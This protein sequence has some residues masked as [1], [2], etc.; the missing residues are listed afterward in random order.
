MIWS[1]LEDL[2]QSIQDS[3]VLITGKNSNRFGTGFVIRQ[4]QGVARVLTCAHVLKDVGGIESALVDGEPVD[5]IVSNPCD[6]LDLAILV[7]GNLWKNALELSEE[8]PH[9]GQACLVAGWYR[10]SISVSTEGGYKKDY[11]ETLN[12]IEGWLDQSAQ[13]GISKISTWKL[14]IG[15]KDSVA[16]HSDSELAQDSLLQPGRS[17]SPVVNMATGKVIGIVRQEED[18]GKSGWAIAIQELQRIWRAVDPHKLY[19]CLSELGYGEQEDLF[20]EM[21]WKPLSTSAFLVRGESPDYGQDWLVK[22][23]REKFLSTPNLLIYK[24]DLASRIRGGNVTEVWQ[25][26]A[27]QIRFTSRRRGST[28]E[29]SPQNIIDRIY[30]QNKTKHIVFIFTH[31]NSLSKTIFNRLI[32]EVWKPILEYPQESPNKKTHTNKLI[33][34]FVDYLNK[35]ETWNLD[36]DTEEVSDLS[37]IECFSSTELRQWFN[38]HQSILPPLNKSVKEHIRTLVKTVLEFSQDG[39]PDYAIQAICDQCDYEYGELEEW[40]K[41]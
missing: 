38:H 2:K 19:E 33:V 37:K 9:S 22:R 1:N 12:S 17:G 39:I 29:I 10:R 25:D 36:I 40:L 7:V 4:Y 35:F 18:E 8:A 14:R 28:H 23:L 21:L 13:I 20:D 6:D 5:N 32:K 3:T 30:E 41:L 11:E 26:L 15:E 16:D 24:I 31:V 27:K 34:F